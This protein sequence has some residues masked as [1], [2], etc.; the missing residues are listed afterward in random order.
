VIWKKKEFI[1]L[2]VGDF[3]KL[4]VLRMKIKYFL[5][6]K[7]SGFFE[8]IFLVIYFKFIAGRFFG[9]WFFEIQSE[10]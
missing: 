8:K 5:E 2:D 10:S 3:E 7:F 9:G 4:K 6:G 1:F